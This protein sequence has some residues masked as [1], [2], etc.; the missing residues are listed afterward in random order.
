MR[1]YRKTKKG[2][3]VGVIPHAYVFRHPWK[4]TPQVCPVVVIIFRAQGCER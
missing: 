1:Y 4:D 3:G 2:K